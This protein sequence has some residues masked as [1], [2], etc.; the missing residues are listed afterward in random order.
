MKVVGVGVCVGVGVWGGVGE[1]NRREKRGRV[2]K[3][4]TKLRFF[5]SL[6]CL[7]PCLP[8]PVELVRGKCQLATFTSAQHCRVC[9]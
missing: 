4:S 7:S 6:L 3:G 5:P 8:A 2:R 9:V 1:G